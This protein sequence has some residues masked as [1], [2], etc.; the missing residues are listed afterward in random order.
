MMDRSAGALSEE[1][2]GLRDGNGIAHKSAGGWFKALSTTPFTTVGLE[3]VN[4]MSL[5]LL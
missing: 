1:E 3:L 5:Y 4:S 2:V